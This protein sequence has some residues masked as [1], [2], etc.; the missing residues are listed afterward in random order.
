[1]SVS[2]VFVI[3][4]EIEGSSATGV[5]QRTRSEKPFIAHKNRASLKR[6]YSQFLI[7]LASEQTQEGSSRHPLRFRD[8]VL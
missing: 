6:F 7:A 2:R 1:V 5:T 3:S 8:F 4:T